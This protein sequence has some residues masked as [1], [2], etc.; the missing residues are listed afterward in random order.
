MLEKVSENKV[1]GGVHQQYQ[2]QSNV[3][4]CQMRFAVFMPPQASAQHKVPVLYW[5]SGLTCS[6]EN[7]M[8]K[9]GAFKKRQ[10]LVLLL[11]HQILARVV[12]EYLMIA[13]SL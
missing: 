12:K 4:S 9:A 2:H 11:L 3:L 13:R 7:F 1:A 8:Q 6:D 5:L 10:S